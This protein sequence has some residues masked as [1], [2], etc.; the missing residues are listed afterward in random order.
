MIFAGLKDDQHKKRASKRKTFEPYPANY[1]VGEYGFYE[2]QWVDAARPLSSI[3][4]ERY[5]PVQVERLIHD[6]AMLEKFLNY[7]FDCA[8]TD[9]SWPP[10]AKLI[11]DWKREGAYLSET[12][13]TERVLQ[14]GETVKVLERRVTFLHQT[15]HCEADLG[16]VYW[17]K[18]LAE[19]HADDTIRKGKVM[20]S[21]KDSDAMALCLLHFA[22]GD[23]QVV[24]HQSDDV[25]I[26]VQ[27]FYAKASRKFEVWEEKEGDWYTRAQTIV[28]ALVF[29]GCDFFDKSW[30]MHYMSDHDAFRLVLSFAK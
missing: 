25:C 4:I 3:P 19:H 24:W 30:L 8:A 22:Q 29:C 21:T 10:N 16:V 11:L 20:L 15:Y 27:E 12:V 18:W 17:T 14:N 2:S 1:E 7:I 23:I 13:E 26:D 6:K 5:H 28:T 9:P